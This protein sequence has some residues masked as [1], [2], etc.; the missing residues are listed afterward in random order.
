MRILAFQEL[1]QR[2]THYLTSRT[3]VVAAYLYGS[4]AEGRASA[5]SDIDLG[6][7][8]GA[9]LTE[10]RLWRV[11]DALAADLRRVLGIDRVDLVLLNLAP[12][13][14]RYEVITKG[15]LLY[16]ADDWARADVESYVLRRYWDFAR[17]LEEYD[18]CFLVSIKEGL[19]ETQR[20]EYEDTAA[21]V[22]A[23]HRRIKETA[24]TRYRAV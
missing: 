19:D 20:R 15:T 21:K 14:I 2:L 18:R 10:D 16:S 17:Y 6:I 23:V 3:D 13:R 9:E 11:E 4:L 7:L 12:V 22:G 1:R 24:G 5:L 8:I